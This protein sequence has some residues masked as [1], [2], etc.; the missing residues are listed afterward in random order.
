[1]CP[2]CKVVALKPAYYKK[3]N[4]GKLHWLTK[5]VLVCPTET[6]TVMV[7]HTNN[8][9]LYLVPYPEISSKPIHDLGAVLRVRNSPLIK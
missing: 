9:V 1:M 4:D 6:C 5:D 8:R 3:M 7:T 2:V